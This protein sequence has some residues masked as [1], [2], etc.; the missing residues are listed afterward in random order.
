MQRP[1]TPPPTTT[2]STGAES[3]VLG[4]DAVDSSAMEHRRIGL[5]RE[6]GNFRVGEV[7]KEVGEW[8]EGRRRVWF[9]GNR[10]SL[11]TETMV[12]Y[13]NG[14]IRSLSSTLC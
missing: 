6:R 1:L 2:Q 14:T 4:G 7:K 11:K 5:G 8:R 10:I 3:L 9:G 12:G 13:S